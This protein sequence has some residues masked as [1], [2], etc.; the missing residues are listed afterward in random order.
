M[1]TTALR[2]D[3]AARVAIHAERSE[4]WPEMVLIPDAELQPDQLVP[5]DYAGIIEQAQELGPSNEIAKVVIKVSSGGFAYLDHA[6]DS[7]GAALVP[8]SEV[9][10]LDG[11]GPVADDHSGNPE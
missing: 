5:I 8:P 2:R 11:E 4:R 6:V 3:S 9:P 10:R 1:L 7:G